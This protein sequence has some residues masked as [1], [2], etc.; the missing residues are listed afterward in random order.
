MVHITPCFYAYHGQFEPGKIVGHT[1][2]MRYSHPLVNI[3][4]ELYPAVSKFFF[5]NS[6]Q[7]LRLVL[8]LRCSSGFYYCCP[9]P[10]I[11]QVVCSCG[12]LLSGNLIL[13]LTFATWHISHFQ[14]RWHF[15]LSVVLEAQ[16]WLC[17]VEWRHIITLDCTTQLMLVPCRFLHIGALFR[18]NID[19]LVIVEMSMTFLLHKV[20]FSNS[21][22]LFART[23]SYTFISHGVILSIT[24]FCFLEMVSLSEPLIVSMKG[25][26]Y[27]RHPMAGL[28]GT[29]TDLERL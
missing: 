13:P 16:G 1:S 22:E 20:G 25:K 17:P 5:E 24:V 6:L 10:K 19:L 15:E 29:F 9:E 28:D 27:H 11:L 26:F 18:H 7:I 14:L 23:D 8:R 12:Q 3:H 4:L 21:T 2:T